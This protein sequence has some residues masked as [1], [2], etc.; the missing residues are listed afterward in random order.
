M[1]HDTRKRKPAR[2]H[3]VAESPAVD[4][5]GPAALAGR[6]LVAEAPTSRA[7]RAPGAARRIVV[8]TPGDRLRPGV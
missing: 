5:K 7:V 6:E 8:F 2:R 3:G 4:A 1:E